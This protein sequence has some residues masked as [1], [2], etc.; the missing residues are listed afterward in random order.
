VFSLFLII[1][2][3]ALVL[4][5]GFLVGYWIGK[6]TAGPV[7]DEN[8]RADVRPAPTAHPVA[9]AEMARINAILYNIDVYDGTERGQLTIND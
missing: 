9:D 8:I 1:I 6:D 2:L 7:V 3:A 4:T 5:A